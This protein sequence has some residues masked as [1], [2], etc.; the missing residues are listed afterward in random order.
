[1]PKR[2]HRPPQ[3]LHDDMRDALLANA[4]SLGFGAAAMLGDFE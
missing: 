4:D 2:V 1:M 3:H